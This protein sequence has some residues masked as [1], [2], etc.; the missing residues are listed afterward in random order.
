MFVPSASLSFR[1]A[2]LFGL[3]GSLSAVSASHAAI[4]T[5]YTVN[6]V[7]G[8][9]PG[10]NHD[11]GGSTATVTPDGI[12]AQGAAGT[13]STVQITPASIGLAGL[14][15]GDIQSI[16]YNT[17]QLGGTIDWQAKFYTVMQP[18]QTTGFYGARL[19]YG[20][21]SGTVH[22]SPALTTVA[23]DASTGST[24]DATG[25][26]SDN[27]LTNGTTSPTTLYIQPNNPSGY[28]TFYT[29]AANEQIAYFSFDAG[30]P[31][32]GGAYDSFLNDITITPTAASGFAPVEIVAAVPEP[33]SLG[34]IGVGA[35]GLLSRRRRTV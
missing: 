22:T 4:T 18:G 7:D 14:T 30:A 25:T 35:L 23:G 11:T 3:I 2:V 32:G 28:S 21:N 20:L 27:W 8:S 33:A 24:T 34:L 5:V 12:F 16:S 17:T 9:Q 10:F 26:T 15:L 1:K 13:Y 6:T 29:S 19:N 31:S